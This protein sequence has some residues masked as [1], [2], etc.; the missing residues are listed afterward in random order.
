[1]AEE[2]SAVERAA[3]AV[4]GLRRVL[5]SGGRLEPSLQQLWTNPFPASRL[6]RFSADGLPAGLR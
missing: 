1:M 2:Q 3:T 4:A 5:E 6:R